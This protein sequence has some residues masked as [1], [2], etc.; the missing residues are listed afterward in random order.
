MNK[1]EIKIIKE[2]IAWMNE[3]TDLVAKNKGKLYI[4]VKSSDGYGVNGILITGVSG[5]NGEEIFTDNE[6]LAIGY[7]TAGSNTIGIKNYAD[8]PDNMQ[9]ITVTAGERLY[10][11]ITISHRNFVSYTTSQSIR[12]SPSCKNVSYSLCGGGG[13]GS[14]TYYSE[15]NNVMNCGGGGGGGYV[16]IASLIPN[17]KTQYPL[18]IGA[19]G[20]SGYPGYGGIGSNGGVTTFNG[21]SANGGNGG[22]NNATSNF[23]ATQFKGGKGNGDGGDGGQRAILGEAGSPGTVGYFSSFTTTVLAGGGGGGGTSK[24]TSNGYNKGGADFGGDSI[25]A[26]SND[27]GQSISG[28]YGNEAMAPGGGG[29]GGSYPTASVSSAFSSYRSGRKG[30]SG[31]GAFRMMLG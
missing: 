18:S 2:D 21:S 7:A 11:T 4:T 25:S 1:N 19:G 30:A 27:Y 9:T 17:Y 13:G 28:V 6:G 20:N 22:G 26:T 8:I 29:G 15:S 14:A 23:E 16:T 12:F 24:Q 3:K 10:P 31:G 5:L